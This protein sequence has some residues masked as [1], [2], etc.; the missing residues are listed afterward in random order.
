MHE[1]DGISIRYGCACGEMVPLSLLFYSTL[2]HKI[3]C[4]KSCCSVQEFESYYCANLLLNF[5]SKEANMYQNRSSR[6]F[7][8][9]T[10]TSILSTV[11]DETIQ[12]YYFLCPHCRWDSASTVNLMEDDPDLLLMSTIAR[13]RENPQEDIFNALIS[14][15]QS[16][17]QSSMENPTHYDRDRHSFASEKRSASFLG[18]QRDHEKVQMRLKKSFERGVWRMELLMEHVEDR[19]KHLEDA[20]KEIQCNELDQRLSSYAKT[21]TN[22]S[23]E[24]NLKHI[25]SL[26]QLS[27][28]SAF[29]NL[30]QRFLA[31]LE[32][33]RNVVDMYPIR[34]RLRTKKTWRCVESIKKGSAGI[35]VKPQ[36]SPLSGDSSLPVPGTWFKKATL[37]VHHIP[38]ITFVHL[39]SEKSLENDLHRYSTTILIE[40]PMEEWIQL[41]LQHRSEIDGN[42]EVENSPLSRVDLDS[43]PIYVGPYED[44][45]IADAF[46]NESSGL[47][48]QPNSMVIR[49]DRNLVQLQ[50]EIITQESLSLTFGF[51][52]EMTKWDPNLREQIEES[53]QRFPVELQVTTQ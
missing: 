9:A 50:L 37:A 3:V 21:V 15:H 24:Q 8:C 22:A 41:I 35:L 33:Y 18:L 16:N 2:C 32:Q 13:E 34:P 44:P 4:R 52:V 14:F 20:W 10:C 43:L 7:A 39:P 23:D 36:I 45:T 5:P 17:M 1:Y 12:K 19:Q 31:P 46:P 49:S 27:D 40:N 11:F 30:K 38:M 25:G 26:A 29:S 42:A 53:R 47:T 48:D 51:C 6:S 28:M